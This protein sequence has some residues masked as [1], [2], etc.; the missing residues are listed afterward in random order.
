MLI[1]LDRIVLLGCLQYAVEFTLH[2]LLRLH[3]FHWNYAK[4]M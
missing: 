4:F 3:W 2:Y 1:I